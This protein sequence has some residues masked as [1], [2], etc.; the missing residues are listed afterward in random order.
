MKRLIHL[1]MAAL[2]ALVAISCNKDQP[3]E[4]EGNKE[5]AVV[6]LSGITLS[7]H[8]LSLKK[9]ESTRLE[10]TFTPANATDKT[11]TWESSA[12]ISP[13]AK[14]SPIMRRATLK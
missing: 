11:V 9:G 13:G 5:P 3:A 7:E 12:T 1:S 14:R 2:V 10:V 8:T 4:D 6:E